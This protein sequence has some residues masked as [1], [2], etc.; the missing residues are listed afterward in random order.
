M[1]LECQEGLDFMYQIN[2]RRQSSYAPHVRINRLARWLLE[3]FLSGALRITPT[4]GPQLETS[5]SGLV[6]K[7]VLDI[8]TA[9]DNT[10]FP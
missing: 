3:E 5:E 6:S 7:L 8:N 9:S 4:Q 10:Q 2:R 1:D